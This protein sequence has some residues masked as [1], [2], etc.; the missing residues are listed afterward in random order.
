MVEFGGQ[1]K[2]ISIRVKKGWLEAGELAYRHREQCAFCLYDSD[3]VIIAV[4]KFPQTRR[5]EEEERE[6]I[7]SN[8]H[9]QS[10]WPGIFHI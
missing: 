3:P 1:R 2:T 5:E 7:A 4:I 8:Y 10:G 9:D 6:R